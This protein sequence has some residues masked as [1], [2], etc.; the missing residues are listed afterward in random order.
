[1][2]PIARK[3]DTLNQGKKKGRSVHFPNLPSHSAE[4]SLQDSNPAFPLLP[5]VFLISLCIPLTFLMGTFRMSPYRVVLLVSFAPALVAWLSG[6]AGKPTL[7]DFCF[8]FYSLWT[9]LALFVSAGGAIS[10]D[11]FQSAAIYILETFGSYLTARVYVTNYQQ[12]LKFIKVLFAILLVLLP[13]ALYETLTH[14]NLPLSALSFIG[15]SFKIIDIGERMGL[16]RAQVIFEH[17][18]LWGV[19]ASTMFGLLTY[20]LGHGKGIFKRGSYGLMAAAATIS[21]VSTGALISLAVQIIIMVWDY[22]TAKIKN[23]WRILGAIAI[24]L[25]VLVDSIST[26]TPFQV[27]ITYLTFSAQSS[28]NRVN[29]WIY[30]TA[31]VW[32]HPIFG[33]GL[34]LF[35]WIRP[36]FMNPSMD[37]FWLVTAVHFGLPA[38]ISLSVGIIILMRRMGRANLPEVAMMSARTG[39]LTTYVGFILSGCTVHYWNSMYCWIMFLFGLGHWCLAYPPLDKLGELTVTP[40]DSNINANLLKPVKVPAGKTPSAR[41]MVRSKSTNPAPSSEKTWLK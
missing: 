12:F 8:L 38:F 17:P 36:R 9:A 39:L 10:I 23:R 19:F 33:L 21:S 32:R 24:A 29:I 18:I 40:D 2:M 26:R 11:V 3:G 25:Y 7:I 22:M 16:Y 15:N 20:T 41:G 1:M 30:G 34:G 6:R 31:E 4:V 14:K 13:L 37:N 35:D 28:Y 5:V 27:F